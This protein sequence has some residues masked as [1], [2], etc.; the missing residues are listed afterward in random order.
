MRARSTQ[1]KSAAATLERQLRAL[2]GER[3]LFLRQAAEDQRS[4]ESLQNRLE[5][6]S[7]SAA[8]EK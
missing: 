7:S 2:R 8:S 6:S 4:I 3:D 1:H 5:A